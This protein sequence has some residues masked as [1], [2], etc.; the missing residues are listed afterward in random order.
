[1]N[2][3][4]QRGALR[5]MPRLFALTPRATP[6]PSARIPLALVVPIPRRAQ[7]PRAFACHAR[8]VAQAQTLGKAL[9]DI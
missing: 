5:P 7:R 3:R 2:N 1:V 4:D 8:L 6:F 9:F